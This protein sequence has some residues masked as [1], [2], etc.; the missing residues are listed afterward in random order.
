MDMQKFDIVP[1]KWDM[2]MA[3]NSLH[4]L[5][6]E[7]R[8]EMIRRIYAGLKPG[9]MFDFRIIVGAPAWDRRLIATQDE[10]KQEW[11]ALFGEHDRFATR[12]HPGDHTYMSGVY[13]KV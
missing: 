3:R 4:F 8:L 1:K 12:T 10:V 5:K 7:E 11:Q 2:I 13:I 6:K 9:G